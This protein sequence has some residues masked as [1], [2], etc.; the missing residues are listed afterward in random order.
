MPSFV[1]NISDYLYLNIMEAGRASPNVNFFP[2][3]AAYEA[4][5]Y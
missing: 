4:D 5:I 2:Y 1:K 3:R